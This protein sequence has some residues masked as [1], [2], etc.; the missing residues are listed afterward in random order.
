MDKPNI[1]HITWIIAFI[2]GMVLVLLKDIGGVV[3][4]AALMITARINDLPRELKNK[5]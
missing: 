4:C 2:L 1:N 5:G 3:L